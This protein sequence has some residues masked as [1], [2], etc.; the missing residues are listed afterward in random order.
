MSSAYCGISLTSMSTGTMQ[1]KHLAVVL[2]GNL[3]AEFKSFQGA[4]VEVDGDKDRFERKGHLSS[5]AS[6]LKHLAKQP[7]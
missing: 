3:G 7:E 1:D 6:A 2:P 4:R 5:P